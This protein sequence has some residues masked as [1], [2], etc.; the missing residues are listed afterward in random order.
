MSVEIRI[1]D[2]TVSNDSKTHG[3]KCLHN[4]ESRV[5]LIWGQ[6]EKQFS[7]TNSLVKEYSGI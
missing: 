5:I 2:Q 1:I 4:S 3:K 6:V 7:K